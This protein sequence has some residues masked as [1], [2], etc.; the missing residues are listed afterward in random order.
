VSGT[1]HLASD[2]QVGGI[3]SYFVS[4]PGRQAAHV[5]LGGDDIG[6]VRREDLD[7]VEVGDETGAL[8]PAQGAI[9]L[10]GSQQKVR[11][12]HG[13]ECGIPHPHVVLPRTRLPRQ[14][15][16]DGLVR[17]ERSSDLST[18]QGRNARASSVSVSSLLGAT[19][20]LGIRFILVNLVPS[21]VL[22]TFVLALVWSGAPSEQPELSRVA[23][24]AEALSGWEGV[25]LFVSLLT[26]ALITQ[27]LQL[28]LVRILE[29]YWDD[30][31][32]GGRLASR[33]VKL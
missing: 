12:R 22:A 10:G 26:A 2:S 21:A 24:H 32:L 9:G 28:G 1:L 14:P 27:P 18:S 23:S 17:S 16:D 4:D 19:R 31:P 6:Y 3:Y 33:C 7:W 30:F 5:I 25:L 29:G 15:R 13:S 8:L 20:D 11:T